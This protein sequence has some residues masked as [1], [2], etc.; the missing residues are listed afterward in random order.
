VPDEAPT[1]VVGHPAELLDIHV[2][3]VAGVRVFIAADQ[4]SGGAV[5]VAEP[6][7]PTA[8]Q[9]RVHGRGGHAEPV[10]DLIG[11]SRCFQRRCT[12]LGTTGCGVRFGCRCGREDRSTIPAGP[13]AR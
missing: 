5:D 2:E 10:T 6:V 7:E 4:F 12:I 9:H 8:H 13:S 11:P 1:A 3:H